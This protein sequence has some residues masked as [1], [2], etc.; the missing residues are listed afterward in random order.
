[1][2]IDLGPSAGFAQHPSFELQP[3]G[4]ANSYA[5][6]NPLETLDPTTRGGDVEPQAAVLIE[7]YQA[8]RDAANYVSHSDAENAILP[9]VQDIV[10]EWLRKRETNFEHP[11]VDRRVAA[12]ASAE[13]R[14]ADLAQMLTDRYRT[15]GFNPAG[16]NGFELDASVELVRAVR[17]HKQEV[18]DGQAA[19]EDF[20]LLDDAESSLPI[21]RYVPVDQRE[22]FL[23]DLGLEFGLSQGEPT[24]ASLERRGFLTSVRALGSKALEWMRRGGQQDIGRTAFTNEVTVAPEFSAQSAPDREIITSDG[25]RLRLVSFYDVGDPAYAALTAKVVEGRL[26]EYQ[27]HNLLKPE[28][29][30]DEIRG[31]HVEILAIVDPE[32]G[33]VVASMRKVHTTGRALSAMPSYKKFEEDGAWHHD[34]K[35]LLL[36]R[37]ADD[38]PV[39]EIGGLWKNEEYDTDIKVE[40]YKAALQTS[41]ERN[42]LWFM[43]IVQAEYGGLL[44]NY[45]KSVVHTLGDPVSVKGEEAASEVR[46]RPV[47]VDPAT[48]YD[49]M[50]D[51]IILA[52]DERNIQKAATR[53]MI[54]EDFLIG[55]DHS[56]LSARTQYRLRGVTYGVYAQ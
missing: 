26:R 28:A 4:A 44:R 3:V 49:D 29:K 56:L 8:L 38:R 7:N 9:I 30:P 10:G 5:H 6:N 37:A 2:A 54:L 17:A 47:L 41:F 45:G 20:P 33:E 1:M 15:T 27:R 52:R 39:V 31:P 11:E 34:G 25:K 36:K 50:V 14:V 42:E 32:T 22:S 24:E 18:A 21:L 46:L 53:A 23:Q 12:Q 55:L 19:T 43:G 35:A 40:L 13:D 16:V 51:E 48:F